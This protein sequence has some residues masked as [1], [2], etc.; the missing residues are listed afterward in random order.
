[1][2]IPHHPGP[3][4]TQN[5]ELVVLRC[6]DFMKT[7]YYLGNRKYLQKSMHSSAELWWRKSVPP[8]RGSIVNKRRKK[9][10][11]RNTA[12]RRTTLWVSIPAPLHQPPHRI[13]EPPFNERRTILRWARRTSSPHDFHHDGRLSGYLMKRN[14]AGED[15]YR[16]C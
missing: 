11:P 1:M 10:L 6:V 13:C 4:T 16:M 8:S 2:R 14:L 3:V 15:L 12:H 5:L 9:G 7:Q